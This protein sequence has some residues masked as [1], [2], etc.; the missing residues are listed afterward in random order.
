MSQGYLCLILHAHLPFVR[1]PEEEYFLEENW[2]FEAITETYIPLI[3][4]FEKLI[5][6]QIYFRVTMSLTPTLVSML[7]DSLLQERYIKHLNRLIELSLKE[8]D[9]TGL[10]ARF[11]GLAVMYHTRLMDCK[12]TFVDRY[13][14]NLIAAFKRFADLGYLE[15]IASAATHSFCPAL[16]S[17]PQLVRA[18][19]RIGVENYR[20]N[21]GCSPRG[22]WLPECGFYPGL[23]QILKESGI[24]YFVLDSHGVMN[25]DPV[26]RYGVYAP[27]YCPESGVAA[28]GRDYE[29]SKQV[30][31]AKEGYPGDQDYREYYKDIGF[32]LEYEYIKP[33]IH[34]QGF[35]INT[36]LKYW[37]IT[38]Q[39]NHKEPYVADWAKEKAAIHA[40]NFMFNRQKQI[41]HLGNYMD[42]K[43]IVVAP[44][45]AELFGHW[46]FEGPQWIDFLMR[47]IACDQT[48]LQTITPSEYLKENPSN[49][50]CM[51]SASSWGYK[52]YNEYWIEASNDWIYRHLIACGHRMIELSEKFLNHVSARDKAGYD[53]HPFTPGV[54]GET[55]LVRRALNQSA[56]ELLL[57]QASDW[58]FIMKTGTMV[59]YAKRRIKMHINRFNRL[60]QDLMENH[61]D[62]QWLAEIEEKDNIFKD[63][64]CANYYF[65]EIKPARV[66]SPILPRGNRR[67]LNQLGIKRTKRLLSP[68]ISLKSTGKFMKVKKLKIRS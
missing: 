43:P 5:A 39:G 19:I 54:S 2:L 23:D 15:I 56:R 50:V 6:D 51:P 63:I 4:V 9:R 11:H 48:M 42:R 33:Y 60:Y 34:P 32:E 49:Q 29:S 17:N 65:K 27:V 28:F 37:R 16:M 62:E 1:H 21:F 68:R 47:K 36:G 25:A 61:L 52:G 13:N 20:Q 24:K 53:S 22:I 59:A 46:W 8:I 55:R 66:L 3:R 40:G 12:Q 10:D 31:S 35:R 38:N 41:E 58:P 64:D 7:N 30:W 26:A 14:R 57:A 44:Y 18:Q 67:S 45:D